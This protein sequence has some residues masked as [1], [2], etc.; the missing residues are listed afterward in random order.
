MFVFFSEVSIK[1]I[2]MFQEPDIKCTKNEKKNY[3]ST[4]SRIQRFD[5]MINSRNTHALTEAWLGLSDTKK[6]QD[7]TAHQNIDKK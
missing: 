7:Q 3:C 5:N 2:L 6:H 1:R 4:S